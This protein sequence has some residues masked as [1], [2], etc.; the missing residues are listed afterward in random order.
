MEQYTHNPPVII[1]KINKCIWLIPRIETLRCIILCANKRI[2]TISSRLID[3][4]QKHATSCNRLLRYTTISGAIN[5]LSN[6]NNGNNTKRL[7]ARHI[8]IIYSATIKCMNKA[9]IY[10]KIYIL[11]PQE[12]WSNDDLIF[13]LSEQPEIICLKV[14]AQTDEKVKGQ[15]SH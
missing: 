15:R 5:Q 14:N 11:A 7:K 13:T 3:W 9:T 2:D 1:E 8:H 6:Q 4:G 10:L 12:M